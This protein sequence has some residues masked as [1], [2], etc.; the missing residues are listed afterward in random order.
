M[1]YYNSRILLSLFEKYEFSYYSNCYSKF[2][3]IFSPLVSSKNSRKFF[4][5]L[6]YIGFQVK[7][8]R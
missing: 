5:S 2:I 1:V 8:S 3:S 7:N 6:V 4:E